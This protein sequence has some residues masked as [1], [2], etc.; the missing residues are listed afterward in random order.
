[1]NQLP[2]PVSI[3]DV[4]SASCHRKPG[5]LGRVGPLLCTITAATKLMLVLSSGLA[6]CAFAATA[7]VQPLPIAKQPIA[8]PHLTDAG[9]RA[10]SEAIAV[11]KARPDFAPRGRI[12]ENVAEVPRPE[13]DATVGHSAPS[14]EFS[15]S[16]LT[17]IPRSVEQAAR[18]FK[19]DGLPVVHIWQGSGT[20][21]S[22]GL[23]PRGL[24]GVYFVGRLN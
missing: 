19:Q 20:S 10:A 21:L 11:L 8:T 22:A 7:S 2:V 16:R 17:G 24:P 14:V 23:S 3:A 6:T 13:R 4:R 5:H 9:R 18:R 1:M 12:V 15:K